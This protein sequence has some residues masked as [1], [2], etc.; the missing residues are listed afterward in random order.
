MSL[1]LFFLTP[2]TIKT[3]CFDLTVFDST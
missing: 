3:R 2:H 1:S